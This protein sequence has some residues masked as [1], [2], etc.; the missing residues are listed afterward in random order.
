M[1]PSTLIL[2]RYFGKSEHLQL[3]LHQRV[4]GFSIQ[5]DDGPS[6]RFLCQQSQV[7]FNS[8]SSAPV[9]PILQKDLRH[10]RSMADLLTLVQSHLF[11]LGTMSVLTLGYKRV[12]GSFY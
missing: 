9:S 6:F 7:A 5:A 8:A 2:S 11:D 3:W 4:P 12:R 10:A 1:Q